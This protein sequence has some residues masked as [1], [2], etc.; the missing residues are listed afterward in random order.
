MGLNN[1]HTCVCVCVCERERE[2]ESGDEG[3][4]RMGDTGDWR[5]G[6]T[7]RVPGRAGL[8]PRGAWEPLRDERHDGTSAVETSLV[9]ALNTDGAVGRDGTGR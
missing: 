2:R 1:V 6:G 9:A 4:G 7:G 3:R 5:L 8:E